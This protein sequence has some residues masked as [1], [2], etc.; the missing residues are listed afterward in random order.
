[1]VLG[2]NDGSGMQHKEYKEDKEYK[3]KERLLEEQ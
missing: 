3:L 1:M 2:R